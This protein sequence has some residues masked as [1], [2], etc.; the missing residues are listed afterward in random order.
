MKTRSSIANLILIFTMLKL[1]P[2]YYYCQ[3]SKAVHWKDIDKY[4][5]KIDLTNCDNDKL[6]I[7]LLPPK[8]S[9]TDSI[10]SFPAIVPG[11]YAINDFGRF[12]SNFSVYGRSGE[13]I[14]FVQLDANR[15]KISSPKSASKIAYDVD[16]TFDDVDK[17]GVFE[18]VGTIFDSGKVFLINT[19]CVFGYF[20]QHY[21]SDFVLEIRKPNGFFPS[22]SADRIKISNDV[23]TIL[24][25]G[26][27]NLVDMPF[28][29]CVPDTSY[30]SFNNSKILV[31]LYSPNKKISS[32]FAA[33]VL[34]PLLKAQK[35]YLGGT[36]PVEKYSFIIYLADKP[37]RSRSFGALEHMHSSLY[38]IPELDTN[39]VRRLLRNVCAHEFYH[40]VTP[41]N[42]HSEEVH[43]FDYQAPKMSKHLWLYE[44]VT[45]YITHH[46][47]LKGGIINREEF[48]NTIS[49]KIYVSK[50]RFNDTLAFTTLSEGVLNKYHDQY[51]NVYFKGALIG[52]C[53]DLILIKESKGRKDLVKLLDALGKK[54]GPEKCFNDTDLIGEIEGISNKKLG[55]F[56]KNH[57]CGNKP[58]PIE[59]LF[60]EYGL[61][62][63]SGPKGVTISFTEGMSN[64]QKS[65]LNK[66]L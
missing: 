7:E 52:M 65:L 28:M 53:I 55:L 45:E 37:T 25:K 12:I 40:I 19:H 39:E 4:H 13:P 50:K 44:G 10:F 24:I 48:L 64:E 3:T 43:N 22:L 29:Y 66:W 36:L 14:S 8:L 51:N 35:E 59:E 17:E 16:D 56:F 9:E 33:N 23:D 30:I 57:V 46:A 26:F 2:N 60:E 34:K 18:P 6:H 63:N 31:S 1:G 20:K 21:K 32:S 58:L 42:I 5:Y 41:L 38:V 61:K 15:Y 47:Q 27:N 49:E 62:I 54:Y 11:T